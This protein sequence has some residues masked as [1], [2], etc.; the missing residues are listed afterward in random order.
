[1][2]PLEYVDVLPDFT[3]NRRG[4]RDLKELSPEVEEIGG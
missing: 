4:W 3:R 1:M 2:L